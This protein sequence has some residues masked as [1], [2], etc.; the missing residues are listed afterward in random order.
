MSTSEGWLAVVKLHSLL[1]VH[2]YITASTS[3]TEGSPLGLS[4]GEEEGVRGRGY[5]RLGRTAA[6]LLEIIN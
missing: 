4:F 2:L 5:E 6:K 1:C 3:R